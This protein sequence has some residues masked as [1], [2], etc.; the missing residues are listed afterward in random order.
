MSAE[1]ADDCRGRATRMLGT[2]PLRDL[3]RGPIRMTPPDAGS[4]PRILIQIV[5]LIFPTWL[6]RADSSSRARLLCF[7][8]LSITAEGA[9]PYNSQA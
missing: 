7:E 5:R 2:K 3:S 6:A 9:C 1:E 8:P 4:I